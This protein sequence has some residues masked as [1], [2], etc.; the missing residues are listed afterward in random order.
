MASVEIESFHRETLIE[1]HRSRECFM[2]PME[3]EIILAEEWDYRGQIFLLYLCSILSA[4]PRIRY[5]TPSLSN[6][7]QKFK[8]TYST[9]VDFC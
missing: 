5:R 2:V 6:L 1:K 9:H 3:T 8:F 4:W 7:Q